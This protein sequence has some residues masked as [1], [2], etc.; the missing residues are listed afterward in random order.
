MTQEK[1]F[2][3]NS[4]RELKKGQFKIFDEDFVHEKLFTFNINK[5]GNQ[6]IV[7]FKGAVGQK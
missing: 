2:E 4:W 1:I 6:S 3:T 5:L 7:K